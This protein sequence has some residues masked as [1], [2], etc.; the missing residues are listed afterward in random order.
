MKPFIIV[1]DSCC[2]LDKPLREKY[3]I[4]YIPMYFSLDETT[5]PADVDWK[6]FSAKE[7]YDLMREGKRFFTSQV[8]VQDYLTSFEGF[9]QKGYDILSISCSSALSASVKA[10][11]VARDELLQ[12]YPDSK[13]ICIDSLNSCFGLGG[14]CITASELRQSG[15]VIDEVAAWIEEN[16]LSMN[17]ECT[18]E[19]L[20]YLKQAGRVSTMSAVFG[21]LLNIKPIIISDAKGQNFAIEK[22]K[23]RATSIDRI[24]ER[25]VNTYKDVNYQKVYIAHADCMDVAETL[26]QTIHQKLG[27]EIPIH[28]GYIGPI[29]GASCGPGTFAVYFYGNKVTTNADE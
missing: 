17:Q 18:V 10:S 28:I 11:Y 14:L 26:K 3:G 2:D 25:M 7:F 20:N 21:G 29:V 19:K 12:K 13:I 1:T 4:E 6:D 27:K 8:P 23:G 15:M 16:K 22:V 24:A 9:I 5:Y